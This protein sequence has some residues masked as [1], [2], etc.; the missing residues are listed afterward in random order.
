MLQKSAAPVNDV[1]TVTPMCAAILAVR[2]P[3]VEIGFF[4][5]EPHERNI[6]E[7]LRSPFTL[8]YIG[9]LIFVFGVLLLLFWFCLG[10]FWG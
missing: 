7:S 2:F 9:C 4:C 1:Y 5:P 3:A 6:P 8:I 10:F